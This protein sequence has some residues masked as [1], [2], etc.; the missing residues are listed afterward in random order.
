MKE[1]GKWLKSAGRYA[2]LSSCGT[3]FFPEESMHHAGGSHL[4]LCTDFH[5]SQEPLLKLL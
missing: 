5:V 3:H 2:L 1:V 4:Y